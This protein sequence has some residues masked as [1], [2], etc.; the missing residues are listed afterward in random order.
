L[1]AR[2]GSGMEASAS[3]SG[4]G[5]MPVC[6]KGSAGPVWKGSRRTRE[7]A[8]RGD[9]WLAAGRSVVAGPGTWACSGCSLRMRFADRCGSHLA[10]VSGVAGGSCKE[11]A[12]G[13]QR[14]AS[15]L[16]R[17]A[18]AD[19]GGRGVVRWPGAAMGFCSASVLENDCVASWGSG[20]TGLLLAGLGQ[21][22]WRGAALLGTLELACLRV[23]ENGLSNASA[24]FRCWMRGFDRQAR[25]RA[26]RAG[27]TRW[28][29]VGPRAGILV[30]LCL[31]VSLPD[32]AW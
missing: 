10:V 11:A 28:G 29:G 3:W 21:W 4:C 19:V 12:R 20:C 32:R 18:N 26:G 25:R 13:A 15:G 2:D 27:A 5:Q 16:L 24:R 9:S 6:Q 30:G 1:I 7:A 17:P 14:P 22:W 8:V 31:V 23:L